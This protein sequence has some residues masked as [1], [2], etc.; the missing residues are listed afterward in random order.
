VLIGPSSSEGANS[1]S[2]S[3]A[4]TASPI[5]YGLLYARVE[6]RR[7]RHA[8]NHG[9]PDSISFLRRRDGEHRFTA[10]SPRLFE[11]AAAGTCQVLR[12][13]DYIG[14]LEP[15]VHYL[16][17]NHD[18]SNVQDVL[19]A[20]RDME[21]CQEVANNSQEQLIDS[22][23]FSYQRLVDDA[24]NGL[25]ADRP[26]A[27]ATTWSELVT[28]LLRAAELC[29]PETMHLHDAAVHL[30]HE[31]LG[32]PHRV[33]RC[34]ETQVASSIYQLDV[35]DWFREQSEYSKS[36]SLSWRSPWIWRALA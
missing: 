2:V 10:I 9:T 7:Q 33:S 29:K 31:T 36:D 20:M 24:V 14:V 25:L 11:A 12:P 28:Y 17:L 8:H 21:R 30:I 16:P 6:A 1:R 32:S 35:S 5:P 23:K 15:W 26:S 13:D 3:R 27:G 19:L 22:G 34:A 4:G 18:F